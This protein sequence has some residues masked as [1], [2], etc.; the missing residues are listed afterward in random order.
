MV[1]INFDECRCVCEN[2]QEVVA[3]E[4]NFASLTS[5]EILEIFFIILIVI[6]VIIGLVFAFNKLAN[7][8]DDEEG[9]T[10]Y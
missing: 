5:L 3:P 2:V 4:L 6:V 10:Y 7:P 9:H 1:E 8:P